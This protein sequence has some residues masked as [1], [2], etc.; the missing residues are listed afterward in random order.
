MDPQVD[1]RKTLKDHLATNDVPNRHR[2]RPRPV[3]GSDRHRLGGAVVA[4]AAESVE[5][6]RRLGPLAWTALEHLALNC[7][8]SERGWSAPIGVR[9]VA[10]GIGV[11][12]DTA[13]RGV[14]QLIR[15]GL[16]TRDRVDTPSGH[17][18]SGYLLHLPAGIELTGRSIATAARTESAP[19]SP[20]DQTCSEGG[21]GAHGPSDASLPVQPD[22]A[23][24]RP[25]ASP[26][27]DRRSSWDQPAL[28]EPPI[29]RAGAIDAR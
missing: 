22:P 28:F 16:I 10:A 8:P 21:P 18:R 20:D 27:A 3:G 12:K 11:T 15:A 23:R 24:N 26:K 7:Q 25:L 13:A 19:R 1:G 6:R 9:H 17:R 4:I 5:W 14:T 2:S 29:A